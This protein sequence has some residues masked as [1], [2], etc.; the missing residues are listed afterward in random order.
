[1]KKIRIISSLLAAALALSL[2]NTAVFAEELITA[3]Q[4]T[5]AEAETTD[6]NGE[7]TP[8]L[9][10]SEALPED[11][12]LLR[13]DFN[14]STEKRI[15][16]NW[17]LNGQ[18]MLYLEDENGGYLQTTDI[19]AC[20][21][22]F[23]Y[24]PSFAI[25]KGLYKVSGYFRTAHEGQISRIR[26]QFHNPESKI[27]SGTTR[28]V[29]ITNE[30]VK[31][32]FYV[33]LTDDLYYIRFRGAPYEEFVQDYCIDNLSIVKVDSIPA[34][35]PVTIG[36][37]VEP[38]AALLSS[39]DVP[40]IMWDPANEEKYDVN[41]IIINHDNTDFLSKIKSNNW[42]EQDIVDYAKQWGG[43]HV[44]D[45]FINV[46][47]SVG[48]VNY[49]SDELWDYLDDYY[50][51]PEEQRASN[52]LSVMYTLDEVMGTDYIG[53]WHDAFKEV[54]I[55]P[56]LSYRMNDVHDHA[57]KYAQG[58]VSYFHK[59][60]DA[61]RR[62]FYRKDLYIGYYGYAP[63]YTYDQIREDMLRT[64][65]D[66]LNRYDTYGI[67]LDF[68]RE[69]W[70]FHPGG[71]Y[72]GLEIMNEFMRQLDDLIAVYE[73]KYGHEIKTA[74]RVAS[75][76]QTNFDFGLD[77]ATWAAEGT[78]DLV[79]V[80]ARWATTDNDMPIALWDSI[81]TPYGVELAAGVDWMNNK[82][83]PNAKKSG[84]HHFTTMTGFAANAFSQGADKVY[85]FN[86]FKTTKDI[87]EE[88]KFNINSDAL[89]I[90]G[91]SSVVWNLITTIGSYDKLME[92]NRRNVLTYNDIKQS[93]ANYN[94]QLPVEI[95]ADVI[96]TLRI[97]VGDV[98][99]GS[100]LTL[101]FSTNNE[102]VFDNP[103]IVYVNSKLCTYTGKGTCKGDFTEY[104]L[105][106]YDIPAAAHDATYMVIEIYSE[107]LAFTIDH[108]E[109]YVDVTGVDFTE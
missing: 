103:P 55:N 66:G 70:L 3:T 26:L 97:P 40:L 58:G 2:G 17:A 16:G 38:R 51:L 56:W 13:S 30:W 44:T 73:E 101:K 25:D 92:Y 62:E 82:T 41:G 93:W 98:V 14:N 49:P 102:A 39:L 64:V 75:D 71:E 19:I 22:G 84:G 90:N 32:E 23:D 87:D 106:C 29:N 104:D 81:L 68:Q 63:D 99:E 83:H 86:Y 94:N 79:T 100:V 7:W 34:D 107:E 108:A 77:V 20:H 21:T 33:N 95:R 72:K 42:D 74:V 109:V 27:I 9:S 1:M 57:T 80:T 105:L 54:G 65:N 69:I 15:L 45:Y 43:S 46:G 36:D 96:S 59:I 8:P 24:Y 18:S 47:S 28:D 12:L 85:L 11:N 35:A 50:A 53:L 91:N 37:T 4:T 5:L 89:H 88:Y 60:P 67:E 48:Q 6:D 52:W 61:Y 78:V 31:A 76:I 10:I